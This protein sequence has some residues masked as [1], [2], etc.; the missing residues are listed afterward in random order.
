MTAGGAEVMTP[1]AVPDHADELENIDIA[2]PILAHAR[3]AA[4]LAAAAS[5]LLASL[6]MTHRAHAVTEGRYLCMTDYAAVI[7]SDDPPYV[8]RATPGTGGLS[9]FFVTIVAYSRLSAEDRSN[10]RGAIQDTGF[11]I[12]EHTFV[13]KF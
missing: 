7:T 11:T 9:K 1:D 10:S 13:A 4:R 3:R 12:D 2:I 6:A 8:G 5:A